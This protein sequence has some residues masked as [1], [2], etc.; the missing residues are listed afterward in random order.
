MKTQKRLKVIQEITVETNPLEI[1]PNL[2]NQ[3]VYAT[4]QMYNPEI[5]HDPILKQ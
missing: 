3:L 1:N 2:D 5:I 4:G